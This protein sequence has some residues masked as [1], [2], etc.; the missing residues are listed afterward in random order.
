VGTLQ[1]TYVIEDGVKDVSTINSDDYRLYKEEG[2][3]ELVKSVDVWG[4]FIEAPQSIEV[5]YKAG[6]ATIPED[7][8]LAAMELVAIR[9]R[10]RKKDSFLKSE[11]VRNV[12]FTY[13]LSRIVPEWVKDILAAYKRVHI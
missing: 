2:I 9:W 11:S 1:T 5:Y 6:Y 8:Q 12:T 13:D 10:G 4:K 3:I 7:L